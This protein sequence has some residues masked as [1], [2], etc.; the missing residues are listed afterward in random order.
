V[1]PYSGPCQAFFHGSAGTTSGR[2]WL[3]KD[4]A[5]AV[6][7]LGVQRAELMMPGV[8]VSGQ[9]EQ[10]TSLSSS[11]VTSGIRLQGSSGD[12][13][14]GQIKARITADDDPSSVLATNP[15]AVT[16]TQ[17]ASAGLSSGSFGTVTLTPS[18]T[19]TAAAMVGEN[20]GPTVPCRDVNAQLT[21]TGL[22]CA[23]ATLAAL[24]LQTV[25]VNP[26]DVSG[27]G[28]GTFTLSTLDASVSPGHAWTARLAQT[29]NSHCTTLTAAGTVGC[30]SAAAARGAGSLMLGGMPATN[31]SDTL[32]WSSGATFTGMVS[33]TG[34][35]A[36]ATSEQGVGAGAPVGTRSGT[37]SYWNGS[38]YS[39]FALS[40][41]A[42]N[43]SLGTASIT[44]K[45]GGSSLVMTLGGTITA[46]AVTTTTWPTPDCTTAA[47]VTT[48]Q[49][50]SV[51]VRVTYDI[52]LDGATVGAFAVN[53]DLGTVT[54]ST[55]YKAAPDA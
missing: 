8:S 21:S 37:V 11:A 5:D 26:V 25:K 55:S 41:S 32:G 33:V 54:A 39:T 16:A 23:S 40:G 3:D 7:E 45:A 27:R 34:Y 4:G 36:A 46:G 43:Q 14:G 49:V 30:S 52:R 10:T 29:Q 18:T 47:C 38:G 12:I 53:L 35:N 15:A 9:A 48:T 1:R 17:S 6:A 2:I 19:G 44:Y 24:G 31:V 13:T 42:V 50:P 20:S 28:L 22:P 51:I